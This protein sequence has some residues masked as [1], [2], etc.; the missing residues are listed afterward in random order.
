MAESPLQHV[1]ILSAASPLTWTSDIPKYKGQEYY[2]YVKEE[3][4]EFNLGNKFFSVF[5]LVEVINTRTIS[6]LTTDAN[7]RKLI[8]VC[9]ELMKKARKVS[10]M[11]SI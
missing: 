10:I 4:E 5:S 3:Y 6:M 11:E 8:G 2:D 9:M 7:L 1:R